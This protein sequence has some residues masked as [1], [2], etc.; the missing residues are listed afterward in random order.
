MSVE[1]KA[2][3]VSLLES[4][5]KREREIAVLRY[6]LSHFAHISQSEMIETMAFGHDDVSIGHSGGHISDKTLYI[7]L[8]YQEKADKLNNCGM[9]EIAGKLVILEQEQNRLKHYI[10]LLELRQAEVIR[11]LYIKRM[12]QKEVEAALNYSTKTIRKTRDEA[13]EILAEM[14]ESVVVGH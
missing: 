3:V 11:L 14:Y 9:N 6:E 8:N 4:Y 5:T 12:T 13:L 2:K 10:S 7:A 1:T